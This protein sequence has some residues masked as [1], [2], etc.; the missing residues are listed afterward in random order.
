MDMM[1]RQHRDD[2]PFGIIE[3]YVHS[4]IIAGYPDISADD[5]VIG[6]KR[7]PK[8]NKLSFRFDL[9][10]TSKGNR[11]KKKRLVVKIPREF[12]RRDISNATSDRSL[13]RAG[14]REYEAL[15]QLFDYVKGLKDDTLGA[16]RPMG[17]VDRINGIITEEVSGTTIDREVNRTSIR[18]VANGSQRRCL[19]ESTGRSGKWLRSLH[20]MPWKGKVEPFDIEQDLLVVSNILHKL[21]RYNIK[22]SFLADI[23]D[24]VSRQFNRICSMVSEG[25]VVLLH[26]DFQAR[27]IVV[28]DDNERVVPFD[29]SL[30]KYGVR[31][32]DISKFI[33]SLRITKARFLFHRTLFD[34]AMIREYAKAFLF[35]YFGEEVVSRPMLNWYLLWAILQKWNQF[36]KILRSQK[37]VLPCNMISNLWINRIFETEIRSILR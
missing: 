14:K 9:E 29:T 32:R 22:K 17:Y 19:L 24:F 11:F 10:I 13:R 5:V 27:N 31:Y 8:L 6:G 21:G 12:G 18:L 30:G 2:S 33:C 26:R 1:L 16:V 4:H 15:C 25:D 20:H 35:G 28:A 34:H 23:G 7:R 37:I 36:N 3:D